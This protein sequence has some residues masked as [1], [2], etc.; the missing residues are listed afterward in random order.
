LWLQRD[1]GG[2]PGRL[3]GSSGDVFRAF[4][5]TVKFERAAGAVV[6]LVVDAG[7]V[8]DIR[9]DRVDTKGSRP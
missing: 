2:E 4:D 3:V 9:F 1:A 6:A 7:R 5:M 8:R